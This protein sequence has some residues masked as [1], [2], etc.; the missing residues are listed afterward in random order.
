MKYIAE[1]SLIEVDEDNIRHERL[2]LKSD[3]E[4]N[5]TLALKHVSESAIHALYT[6]SKISESF[7]GI[8]LKD[9]CHHS[10]SCTHTFCCVC[11][12]EMIEDNQAYSA[13]KRCTIVK[14]RL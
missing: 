3:Y 1:I 8:A 4:G 14:F 13:D 12:N 5:G 2:R 9:T 10:C 6:L 11:D 7:K